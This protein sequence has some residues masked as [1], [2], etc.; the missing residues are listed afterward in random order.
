M[1]QTAPQEKVQ[2]EAIFMLRGMAERYCVFRSPDAADV[3]PDLPGQRAGGVE[4][5]DPLWSAENAG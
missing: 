1:P 4:R 2:E 5:F 3:M